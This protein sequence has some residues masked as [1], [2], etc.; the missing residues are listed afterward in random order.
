LNNKKY[1]PFY[2]SHESVDGFV[3]RNREMCILD[4]IKENNVQISNND[5][6]MTSKGHEL[7]SKE[8]LIDLEQRN[9]T[10]G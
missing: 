10:H 6:H 3:V 9:G 8:I 1:L 4:F 7:W 2:F 5:A